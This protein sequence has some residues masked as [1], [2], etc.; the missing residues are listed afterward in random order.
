MGDF[1][2]LH[3]H[4]TASDGTC[5]PSQVVQL[6]KEAGL[7]AFALTDH[8]TIDGVQE[9]QEAGRK[10][11]ME[12]ISGIE[13]SCNYENVELH[14]LGLFADI[15]DKQF[16]DSLEYLRRNRE[17]RN[18]DMVALFQKDGLDIT[19]EALQ[20]GNPDTV[21][22][23]AHFARILMEKGYVKTKTQAFDRY[24]GYGCPYYIPKPIVTPEEAMEILKQGK[25][26]PVL[27][28]P[29]LYHLGDKKTKE[30]I[31]YLKTL[32]LQGVEVYHSSNNPFESE[33]LR[34]F[35]AA[36]GLLLTG[37]SDFH[38]NNKPDIKI[39]VGRGGLRVHI[40][41]LDALKKRK[42]ECYPD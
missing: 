26:V 38:G 28:H 34:S 32:G 35:A 22:T 13:M 40:S 20:S 30:C 11:D 3:V 10:L 1:V 5:S 9:A 39:G 24:V 14:I 29:F 21:I 2:D 33:K 15:Q 8:D 27:A 37:G 7:K 17:K 31:A 36:E 12:V 25:C 4:S 18:E 16:K 23:R 19:M 6:A 41:L 42:Q